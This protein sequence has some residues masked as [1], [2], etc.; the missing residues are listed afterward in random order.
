MEKDLSEKEVNKIVSMSSKA[1]KYM[2]NV[3]IVR[4]IYVKNRIIN[5]IIK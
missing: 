1:N 4:T 5:Y 3:D 2:E